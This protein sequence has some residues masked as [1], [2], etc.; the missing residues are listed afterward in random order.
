[1]P[2]VNASAKKTKKVHL[3]NNEKAPLGVWLRRQQIRDRKATGT[4]TYTIAGD[5]DDVVED[6]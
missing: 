5:G 1:M 3:K 4:C 6:Q 2:L